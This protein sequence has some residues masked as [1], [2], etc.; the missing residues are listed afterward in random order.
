ML[1]PNRTRLRFRGVTVAALTVAVLLVPASA[2]VAMDPSAAEVDVPAAGQTLPDTNLNELRALIDDLSVA[3][4]ELQANNLTL[5]QSVDAL[6]VERDRLQT[7]LTRF[8]TLYDPI[9]ADRQLLT[10]LRKGL[11]ETRPEAEAQLERL[12][13]LALTSNPQR[14]GRLID[15][16]EDAAP[17]FLDWRFTEFGSTQEATQAYINSGANVFDSTMNELRNEVLLSVANRLDGILTTI[18]RIR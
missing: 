6:S 5:Q 16:V 3:N 18:D 4:D 12:H 17:A 9:E 7:S 8:D 11:P 1:T 2:A 10:E 13:D 15:R 14:L